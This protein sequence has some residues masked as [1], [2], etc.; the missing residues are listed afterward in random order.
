MNYYD[1]LGIPQSA[2]QE[3]IRAAY[4][5]QIKYFHPDVFPGNP[6][7]AKLKTLQLNE[8]YAVLYNPDRRAQY[9][10]ILHQARNAPPP[11]PPD[12]ETSADKAPPHRESSHAAHQTPRQASRRKHDDLLRFLLG[13]ASVAVIVLLV[14]LLPESNTP[15][16][17]GDNDLPQISQTEPKE[18]AGVSS[19]GGKLVPHSEPL[20]FTGQILYENGWDRVAPFGVVT[21]GQENFFIKLKDRTGKDDILTFFVR[22]GETAEVDVPLGTYTLYYATGEF[23]YG[24]EEL[25]GE[26]TARFRAEELFDFYEEDGYVNGWTVE[27]YLQTNGNLDTVPIDPGEF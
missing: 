7:I 19:T 4:L 6:E 24:E 9:D 11:P 15:E 21:R 2:S 22:A 12:T 17:S 16:R 5:A 13:M 20:P 8:A 10:W 23:W 1:V 27:L 14:S 26:S 25:F 3:E 18:A